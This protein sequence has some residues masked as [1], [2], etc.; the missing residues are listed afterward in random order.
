[1]KDH[2]RI[3]EMLQ[4]LGIN[5]EAWEKFNSRDVKALNTEGNKVYLEGPIIANDDAWVM[6]MLGNE[7]FITPE[8]VRSAMNEVKGDI[9]LSINSPGGNVFAASAI[10]DS[11]IERD[12]PVDAKVSG[13]AASAAASIAL[14]ARKVEMSPMSMMMFHH[15]WSSVKGNANEHRAM[16]RT[17]DKIDGQILDEMTRRTGISRDTA[18]KMLD[19][20]NGKGTFLTAKEAVEAKFADSVSERDTSETEP[21]N[22]I[23]DEQIINRMRDRM[24]SAYRQTIGQ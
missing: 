1:M 21:R 9:V 2:S 15:A 14:F 3:H 12:D 4:Y 24:R 8:N 22:S 7:S 6:E 19:G 17:L 18:V 11:I 10:I 13:I 20:D 16:A 23:E 5:S